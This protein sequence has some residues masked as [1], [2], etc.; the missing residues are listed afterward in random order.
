MDNFPEH[1]KDPTWMLDSLE[2]IYLTTTDFDTLI[3]YWFEQ[4]NFVDNNSDNKLIYDTLMILKRDGDRP[5]Y[6]YASYV[7]LTE[8]KKFS[9]TTE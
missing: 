2:Q 8:T 1:Y 4:W 5:S 3:H 7:P 6:V 9:L